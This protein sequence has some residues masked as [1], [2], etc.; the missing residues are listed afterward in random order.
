MAFWLI[1][2]LGYNGFIIGKLRIQSGDTYLILFLRKYSENR[3]LTRTVQWV[4]KKVT[5]S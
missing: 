5:W 3:C 1:K 2:D 4:V